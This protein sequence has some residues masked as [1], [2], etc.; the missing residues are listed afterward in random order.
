MD[1]VQLILNF[2][3]KYL[4]WFIA[5]STVILVVVCWWMSTGSLA[6]Q[7]STEAKNIEG[8]F[9]SV[10]GIVG[11]NSHPTPEST[12]SIEKKHKDLKEG[13]LEV[14][15]TLYKEQK[16]KNVWPEKVLGADFVAKVTKLDPNDDIPY[17][18]RE[19]YQNVIK[20]Y[21]RYLFDIIKVRHPV[22]TA[23]NGGNV[24]AADPRGRGANRV[25]GGG[26]RRG[27]ENVEMVGIVD[28]DESDQLKLKERYEWTTRPESFQI[29]LRQE[30]LWVYETLL[31]V[32][33]KTNIVKEKDDYPSEQSQAAVKRIEWI[34]IGADAIK[35]WSDAD[36]SVF[37]IQSATPGADRGRGVTV[38]GGRLT[39]P[40]DSKEAL[41]KDRYVDD[42][43]TPL[44]AEAKHPYAE[45][46]MMPISMK[47]HMD[48]RKISK[49]L[50]ECVNQAMPIEVRRVRINP[51][52]G[53]ILEGG[54]AGGVAAASAGRS[55]ERESGRRDMGGRG[56]RTGS[57]PNEGEISPFDVP[58]EIQGIIYIYNQPDLSV[59]GTGTALD[60]PSEGAP[61]A[62][63]A[64][65]TVP[66][67]TIPET[68]PAKK[69]E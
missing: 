15:K 23:G 1:K 38:A 26:A 8:K 68:T 42:K 39:G 24:N 63:P 44:E 7:F 5:L 48:Q 36:Q 17:E 69:P 25:I 34:E 65:E 59:L 28:W 2:F 6:T 14:W 45:F 41:L 18:L 47:V 67:A 32:I 43:G 21:F 27:Q 4:F 64:G 22:E 60:K 20:N 3:K 61:A 46:K 12:Q 13:V 50:A 37:R 66:P 10:E 11:D 40:T 58:V 31:Q 57:E 52:A 53:E 16:D 29:R 19:K 30:D 49:L 55:R 54:A 62:A 33:R 56:G 35:S 51:G 9:T